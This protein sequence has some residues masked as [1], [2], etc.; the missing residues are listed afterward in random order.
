MENLLKYAAYLIVA[1]YGFDFILF[2]LRIARLYILPNFGFRL[3]LKKYGSWAGLFIY[4]FLFKLKV[5]VLF[6]S[7]NFF[8]GLK[9]MVQYNFLVYRYF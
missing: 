2:V 1:K 8:D 9:V 6:F 7:Q 4:L 3:N 5:F